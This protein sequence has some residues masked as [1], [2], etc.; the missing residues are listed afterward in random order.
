MYLIIGQGAAGTAAANELKRLEAGAAVTVITDEQDYFYSRLD[1]PGIVGGTQRPEEA[2]LQSA[3]QFQT[4]EI[5]CIVGERVRR[6]LPAEHHVELISGRRLQYNKLLLATGAQPSMPNL[7]AFDAKGVYPLWTMAQA[8]ELSMAAAEAQSAVV[9]GAGLIGLKT[10]LALKSRGLKITVIERMNRVLPQQLDAIGAAILETKIRAQGVEV[11]TGLAVDAVE[12]YGGAVVGVRS[13][14]QVLPCDMVIVAVGVRP[15]TCLAREAG[16]K[17]GAGIV[18]DEFLQTS[19]PD[20]YAA[21]DAAEVSDVIGKGP[22]V[23]AGWPAA[24]EQGVVAARNM[25][26]YSPVQY[27]GYLVKNSIELAGI[28]LVSAGKVNGDG[29]DEI[30]TYRDGNVYKRLVC[31]DNFLRG[32]LL[33]GD[34]RQAGVLAGAL[35]RSISMHCA[36]ALGPAFSFADFLHFEEEFYANR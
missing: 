26:G 13:G 12:T 20:I 30:L 27:P 15:N 3:E 35:A 19:G 31:K 10:A 4:R 16:L 21:G 18:T 17:V 1:L 6:I 23:S 24:V 7:P 5:N 33:M 11:L 9:I 8:S 28:P 29:G 14:K 2:V 34:I 25:I 22:A 36:A 32:F